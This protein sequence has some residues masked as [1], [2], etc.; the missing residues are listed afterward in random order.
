[1]HKPAVV[2]AVLPQLSNN[3]LP[4][5]PRS[6]LHTRPQSPS[7]AV[8]HGINDKAVFTLDPFLCTQSVCFLGLNVHRGH[9]RVC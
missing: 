2:P 1:M 5:V 9:T 8:V 7:G 4:C 3:D 6:R